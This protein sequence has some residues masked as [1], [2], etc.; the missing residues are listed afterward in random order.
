MHKEASPTGPP[1]KIMYILLTKRE[2]HTGR[3][4]T[5]TKQKGK[6][7]GT[8]RKGNFMWKQVL[9]KML[10]AV[11]LPENLQEQS[12]IGEYWIGNRTI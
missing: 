5:Q 3:I 8:K 7:A 10:Q 2:G 1:A 9:S 12:T 11:K 6:R 4:S